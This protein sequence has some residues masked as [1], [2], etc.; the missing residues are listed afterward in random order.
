MTLEGSSQNLRWWANRGLLRRFVVDLVVGELRRLRPGGTPSIATWNDAFALDEDAG[1]DSLEL[2]QIAT[3]LS[4]ALHLHQ[5][6]LEDY[7]LMRR[8]VGDWVDIASTSLDCHADALSFLTSGSTGLPKTCSHTMTNLLQEA[9]VLATLFAGTKRLLFA[10]PSHH[11]YGF[12]FTVLLPRLLR[13]DAAALIDLRESIPSALAARTAPGDLVIAHPDFW[14]IALQSTSR[15]AVDVAG[16]TST[17]PCADETCDALAAAGLG[18]LVQIY[19]SSE[20]AGIGW[21]AAARE[22][23]VL[24]PYWSVDPAKPDCLRREAPDGSVSNSALQDRIEW[25]DARHFTVGARCDMAVQVGGMNV[26]PKHVAAVLKQNPLVADA[27]VRLMR[28][29][30]GNRLKAYVVL[31]DEVGNVIDATREITQWID[32]KLPVAQRPKALT[33]GTALPVTPMGKPCDWLISPA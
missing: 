1:A 30:E 19:G 7:L 21:R 14:R 11:I 6:G 10:V 32:T 25:V 31:A 27:A 20:T 4:Q 15:F 23:Y 9:F 3:A 26:F 24:F 18:R 17:G 22:P 16:V 2:L 5:A 29:E 13:L 12:L 33:V 28:P 8:T